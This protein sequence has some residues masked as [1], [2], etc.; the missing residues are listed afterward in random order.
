MKT[1]TDHSGM[2][3]EEDKKRNTQVLTWNDLYSSLRVNHSMI[4]VNEPDGLEE[5]EAAGQLWLE[6][7]ILSAVDSPV[8]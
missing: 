4:G 1:T 6:A 5:M 2:G 3:E 7:L 8:I